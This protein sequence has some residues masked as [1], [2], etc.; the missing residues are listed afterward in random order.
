M[1]CES[2]CPTNNFKIVNPKESETYFQFIV[3]D[4]YE[5]KL[6]VF[7]LTISLLFITYAFHKNENTEVEKTTNNVMERMSIAIEEFLQKSF[8][9]WGVYCATNPF[10]VL[11]AG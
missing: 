1:D 6:I 7:F 8:T 5:T 3:V 9:K 10:K 4:N 11:F 2:M